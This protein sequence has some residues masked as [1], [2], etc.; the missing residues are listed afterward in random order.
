MEPSTTPIKRHKS[1]VQFSR[2]HHFGL[3]LIWKIRQGLKANIDPKRI[4]DYVLFFFEEDLKTHFAEE[5]RSLFSKLDDLD[6][7]KLQAMKEHT[8]IYQYIADIRA[9]DN[10]A[11]QLV[12]FADALDRHIR[13]EERVLFNHLQSKLS[14]AEL[15]K[16]ALEHP[17]RVV[18]T[19][20]K[21]DDHF[22]IIK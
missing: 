4:S 21:W 3:L 12:V 7:L 6:A 19:D 20:S 10:N 16:L 15:T 13:F 9:D 8:E 22:W 14:D 2:E 11:E 5:E 17:E 18:D 1:I